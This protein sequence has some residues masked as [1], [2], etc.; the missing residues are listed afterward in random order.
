MYVTHTCPTDC[1][2]AVCVCVCVCFMQCFYICNSCH[3]IYEIAET[4]NDIGTTRGATT[5]TTRTAA[6]PH[7]WLVKQK[8]M[9]LLSLCVC[10]CVCALGKGVSWRS[11]WNRTK[12]SRRTHKH[13]VYARRLY[14]TVPYN[15]N[16]YIFNCLSSA[17]L[18]SLPFPTSCSSSSLF[19]AR[20][21]I[22]RFF[23]AINF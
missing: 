19:A 12:Q 11:S 21:F 20:Q 18:H 17:S 13:I 9:S 3:A 2:C 7:W 15:R 14:C 8:L 5:T 22:K 16:L 4:Q 6:Q 23:V 10:V 1:S